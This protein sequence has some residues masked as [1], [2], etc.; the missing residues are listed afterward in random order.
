MSKGRWIV[1][2]AAGCLLGCS[3]EKHGTTQ[4]PEGTPDALPGTDASQESV[5]HR[6]DGATAVT[7]DHRPESVACP[8]SAGGLTDQCSSDSD[9][10]AGDSCACATAFHGNAIHTNACIQSD[11]RI[12]SD[13]GPSGLCSPAYG[14]YCNS[15]TGL[16]CRS[17]AD[18]CTSN[19]DCCADPTRPVCGYAPE[20]G[21][22]TCTA[23]V[24]CNG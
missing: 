2:V 8:P 21:H 9:C 18:E 16:H 19:S 1:L 24:V 6:C 23:I 4:N 15:F 11:C 14:G 20:L 17:A 13:C 10:G 22:W 5:A 7:P 12:D 3:S